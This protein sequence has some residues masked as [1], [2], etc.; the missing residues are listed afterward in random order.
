VAALQAAPPAAD[1]TIIT[2]SRYAIQSLTH[3]LDHHEDA[4]WIGVPNAAWIKAAAYQLWR[5][6]APTHLKWVKGHNGTTGNEE[7]NKLAVKGTNKLIPNNIDLLIP[8][9]FDPTGLHLSTMTQAS[10]YAFVSNHGPP[11]TLQQSTNQ[12]RMNQCKELT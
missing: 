11:P 12:P 3:S 7:A 8:P 9:S 6:S 10:A 2:D 1:L 5:R 4:A